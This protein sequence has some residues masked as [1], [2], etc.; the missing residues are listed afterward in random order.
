MKNTLFKLNHQLLGLVLASLL[1]VF[2]V[3]FFVWVGTSQAQSAQEEGDHDEDGISNNSDVDDDGDGAPDCI[4]TR[5]FAHDHDNDGIKDGQDED[6]DNDGI[7]DSDDSMPLDEDNDGV[8][9][10]VSNRLTSAS[11]DQDGDGIVDADERKVDKKNHDNDEEKDG[12]DT[13]DDNDGIADSEET[14]AD[15][16]DHDND[17]KKDKVD[18]DD[19]NDGIKDIEE[20]NCGEWF[21]EDNDGEEDDADSGD[22]AS[23]P[24]QKDV[25]IVD[26]SF[27][28]DDVT[29]STGDSI[30]WTNNDSVAHT[31]T[32]D[33]GAFDSGVL[34]PGDTYALD[35]DTAGTYSYHC[36]IHSTMT[37][38]IT[39]EESDSED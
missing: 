31:V 24:E 25:S 3:T 20:A 5:E 26:M 14:K 9:D 18:Q 30:L 13:D 28:S 34:E 29:I 22:D 8:D 11:E 7:D 2:G 4:E 33:T 1:V 19:D 39:V 17:D 12:I 16:R 36:S 21:D 6:D 27:S 37:G 35:F 32:S 15:R 23:E 38:T 10:A